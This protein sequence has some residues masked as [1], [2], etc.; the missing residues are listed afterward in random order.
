MKKGIIF[1]LGA[2]FISGISIFY[3]KSIVVNGLDPLIFN[4]IKNGGVAILITFFL[5]TRP[6]TRSVFK[7]SRKN[8]IRL[9]VIGLL[10]GSIPFILFFSGLTMIPA[11]EANLIQKSLFLWVA[12]LAVPILKEKISHIQLSG[13]ALVVLSNFFIGGF[14]GFSAGLGEFLILAATLF[15]AVEN[16]VSKKTLSHIDPT[17][18]AWGRMA[19]GTFFLLLFALFQGKFELL[20]NPRSFLVMPVFFSVLLL[21]GYVLCYYKA[22]RLAPATLVTSLLILATPV[23]NILTTVFITHNLPLPQAAG[24]TTTVIGLSLISYFSPSI[25][26]LKINKAA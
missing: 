2:S 4:I 18:V 17:M 16:I 3:N 6:K 5:L 12:L 26:R 15:W 24:I 10:G 11:T 1:A 23:T 21:T 14:T 9:L 22:L 20:T 13:Y 8:W 19:S 7:L 25:P